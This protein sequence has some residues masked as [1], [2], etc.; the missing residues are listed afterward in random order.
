[1]LIAA[2]ESCSFQ[3][4]VKAWGIR[5]TNRCV[6]VPLCY[7][8]NY[9]NTPV[10]VLSVEEAVERAD[11]LISMGVSRAT[12]V[13]GW[14]GYQN[15]MAVPYIKAIKREFPDLPLNGAFGP[16]NKKSLEAL[17][18]AGLDQYGCGLEAAPEIVVKIKGTNDIPER[19]ETLRNARDVGLKI[20]SG[21][22]I[23]VEENEEQLVQLLKLLKELDPDRVFMNPLEAY[24]DTPMA[25]S[26]LPTLTKV[27]ETVAKTKLMFKNKTLGLKVIQRGSFIPIEFLSLFVFAGISLVAPPPDINDM[28]VER[29]QRI[30][31]LCIRHPEET[32]LNLLRNNVNREDIREFMEIIQAL[33]L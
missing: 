23:G 9:M 15:E 18:A 27:V 5:I 12:L 10:Y 33:Q 14:L 28:S 24:P 29:F 16:I 7:Y 17:R 6:R 26:V 13:S 3:E 19:M 4:V 11:L 30:L 32:E 20:S 2:H 8:C 1:M 21:Y 22:I 31:K 25:D